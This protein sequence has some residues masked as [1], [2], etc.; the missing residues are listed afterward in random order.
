MWTVLALENYTAQTTEHEGCAVG[1]NDLVR[2]CK[3]LRFWFGFSFT[4]L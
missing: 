1:K 3:K 2:C 4:K